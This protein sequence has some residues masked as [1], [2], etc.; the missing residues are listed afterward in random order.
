[1]KS[2]PTAESLIETHGT[3]FHQ[4]WWNEITAGNSYRE[5]CVEQG[6]SVI[7]VLP[8]I[9]T[10]ARPFKRIGMP[11][12]SHVLGPVFA[13]PT[14]DDAKSCTG[15]IAITRALLEQLPDAM[16]V[17]FRLHVDI[18]NSLAFQMASFETSTDYTICIPAASDDVLWRGMRDKTRNVIRRASDVLT[19]Q[20]GTASD[21]VDFYE[22]NLAAAGKTNAY[23]GSMLREAVAAAIARSQGQAI[24][25]CDGRGEP[26]AAIFTLWDK[27]REYYLLSTRRPSSMAGANSFAIWHAVQHAARNGR[28]FDMDGIHVVENKSPNLLLFSGFGGSIVPRVTVKRTSCIGRSLFNVRAELRHMTNAIRSIRLKSR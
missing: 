5:A 7:G 28:I 12:L 27:H 16:H 10:G 2:F 6:G 19:V 21:F 23:S 20:P 24:M 3:V 22:H 13:R 1:M 11:A 26:Q 17:F 9:E 25:A 15:S 4:R 14:H 18:R 8:Y